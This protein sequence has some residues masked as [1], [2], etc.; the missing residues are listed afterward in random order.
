ML[1]GPLLWIVNNRVAHGDALAFLRRV[2]SYRA[3]LGSTQTSHP[4]VYLLGLASGSPAAMLALALLVVAL[5]RSGD[6]AAALAYLARFRPWAACALAL[7]VF[8]LAGQAM[9]GAPTHHPERALL[10]VWLLATLAAVD[11]A[12]V[13]RPPIWRAVPVALLLLVDYRNML[14]DRGVRRET[15]EHAGRQLHALVPRGERVF[16]ATPDY[17]YFA[18]MAAFGRPRD[19]AVDSQDPRVKTSVTLLR[20]P[21]NAVV[22]LRAENATWLVAP[23]SVVFP[24][25][26]QERIR[27]GNLVIY[28]LNPRR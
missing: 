20:D 12:A 3:A 19:V 14:A 25:A 8:L 7:L 26:F 9:G 18:V 6:R 28:E 10:L 13:V 23:S 27:D 15:E 1:L 11:V 17:G 24:L 4:W 16:A 5:L 21:W 2:A 22:R